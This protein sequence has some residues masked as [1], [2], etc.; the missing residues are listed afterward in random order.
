MAVSRIAAVGIGLA[1]IAAAI[2]AQLFNDVA[3]YKHTLMGAL[4]GLWFPAIPLLPAF[5]ALGF[6]NPLRALGAAAAVIPFYAYA[7]YVDCVLPYKGG[8][9]SMVYVFVIPVGLAASIIG[10]VLTG[11]V[12]RVLRIQIMH[13]SK[14]LRE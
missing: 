2:A 1:G 6:P 7:Y 12:C 13:G 14:P 3:C 5:F 11:P 10:A 8:G 4:A 9:A